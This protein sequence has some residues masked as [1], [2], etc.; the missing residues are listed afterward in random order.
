VRHRTLSSATPDSPVNY[1]GLASRIPEGEQFRVGDPGAPDTVRWH[2]GQSGA[3]NLGTLRL[4]LL[5]LGLCFVTEGLVG[6]SG[7]RLKLFVWDGRRF[8]F[9]KLQ[10]HK[11]T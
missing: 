8:L 4:T 11:P 6:R 3:P 10:Y 5:L 2:T 7:F 9:M 1:S